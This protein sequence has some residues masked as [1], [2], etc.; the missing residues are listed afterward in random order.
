MSEFKVVL[1]PGVVLPAGL[2]YEGLVTAL[3]S[4]VEVIVKELEL[5]REDAPPPDY[6]LD[7]EV[8]GVLREA[9]AHGWD[10][11]H[12]VGYSAGAAAAL[13]V[14]ARRPTRLR[15]LGLLEPAWA[16]EWEWSR[17]HTQLW[18]AYDELAR[19]APEQFMP[20]F[21]RLQVRPEV[22]LPVPPPGPAPPWM[23]QRPEG[24]RA[25]M[26]AFHSH[27]L[28]RAALTGFD[29]PVYYA[30]GGLSNPIQFG[31]VADR[32]TE[33]FGDFTLEVFPERHHFDP[34]HR[35][36]PEKLAR[37]LLAIWSRGEQLTPAR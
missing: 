5:Y 23:E 17:E 2:A 12:L 33:V 6:S 19:S 16:G 37:S 34:P 25:M 10:R 11:F 14:A 1:L 15:S 24:I 26:H 7:T 9:D 4:Q 3:G 18:A 13:A 32:L 20:A 21:M 27:S 31:E 29:R 8:T 36:E 35:R 22:E 30:L 28:D